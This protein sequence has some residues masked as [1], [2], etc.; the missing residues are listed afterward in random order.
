MI[1]SNLY[2]EQAT[3]VRATLTFEKPVDMTR[4]DVSDKDVCCVS[5]SSSSSSSLLALKER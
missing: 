5:S 2:W 1:I 4:E 3:V